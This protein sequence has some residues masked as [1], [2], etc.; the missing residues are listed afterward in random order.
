MEKIWQ[1]Q[2]LER[3]HN[4]I[5]KIWHKGLITNEVLKNLQ[6]RNNK[7]DLCGSHPNFILHAIRDCIMPKIFWNQL[8]NHNI[9]ESFFS[10][11]LH[12]QLAFSLSHSGQQTAQDWLEMW[13][14]GCHIMWTWQNKMLH[15]PNFM[16]PADL[17]HEV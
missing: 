8:I 13:A 15:D 10:A 9:K 6:L 16:L 17:I 11:S 3:V 7:C 4:F 1:L 14:F 12:D 2:V 5:W